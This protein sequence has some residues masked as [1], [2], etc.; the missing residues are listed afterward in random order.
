VTSLQSVAAAVAD[1]LTADKP[2]GTAR[3]DIALIGAV[4]DAD[5]LEQ[6]LAWAQQEYGS[7][8][9]RLKTFKPASLADLVDTLASL[10]SVPRIEIW[11]HGSPHGTINI[12]GTVLDLDSTELRDA[13]G[14]RTL[15][16]N[17][18]EFQG[19]D[20]GVNP[21]V[22]AAFGRMV[23]AREIIAWTQTHVLHPITMT[24]E[25]PRR[26]REDAKILS[27]RLKILE[28]YLPAGIPTEEDAIAAH[29]RGLGRKPFLVVLEYWSRSGS[30]DRLFDQFA[31]TPTKM[32]QDA[33][34]LGFPATGRRQA[35]LL[36]MRGAE[37]T[38]PLIDL[39]GTV[40]TTPTL[41]KVVITL[42]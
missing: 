30:L 34:G 38:T 37:A 13:I 4:Q 3:I 9:M 17:S 11:A 39:S 16:L 14:T 21:P 42:P 15:S 40:T 18:I 7:Q 12:A 5:V 22:L 24:P 19:C 27:K 35:E 26:P 23:G 6:G 1:L 2:R 36:R 8:G 20:V 25:L 10:Q 33:F 41:Q 29:L 31:R 32:L 28:P